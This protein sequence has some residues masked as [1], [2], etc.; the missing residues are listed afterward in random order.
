MANFGIEIRPG[1]QQV[2][3]TTSGLTGDPE[4]LILL[5]VSRSGEYGAGE[6]IDPRSPDCGGKRFLISDVPADVEG[7]IV[8]DAANRSNFYKQAAKN[9]K[10][11]FPFW[12]FLAWVGEKR[13]EQIKAYYDHEYAERERERIAL[14]DRTPFRRKT[15]PHTLPPFPSDEKKAE[16]KSLTA[17]VA[18]G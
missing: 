10:Y 3:L 8:L 15:N 13:F 14:L 9:G 1:L 11:V 2:L 7:R 6:I 5:P 12:Q 17:A 18:A 4:W 16:Q